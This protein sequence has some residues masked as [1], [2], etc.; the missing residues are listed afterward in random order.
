M[1]PGTVR[2]F[3]L[4]PRERTAWRRD[5]HVCH[6]LTAAF[7]QLDNERRDLHA[8]LSHRFTPRKGKA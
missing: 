1:R 6:F 3:L 8:L 5:A 2:H 4:L 7:R